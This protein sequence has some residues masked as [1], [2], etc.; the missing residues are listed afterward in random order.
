MDTRKTTGATAAQL[1]RA[2]QL[3]L[4]D[5]RDEPGEP[6]QRG[7]MKEVLGAAA[8]AGLWSPARGVR[9]PVRSA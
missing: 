3:G 8:K 9:G 6:L 5:L 4:V 1:W 2:N 7:V